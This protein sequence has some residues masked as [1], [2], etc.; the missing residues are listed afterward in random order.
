[1]F[2]ILVVEDDRELNKTVCTYLNQ[3]GYSTVGCHNAER[4]TMPC[5]EE[6]YLTSSF[7]IS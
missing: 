2:Q 3:N 7:L 4:R 1:M 6:P 5:M